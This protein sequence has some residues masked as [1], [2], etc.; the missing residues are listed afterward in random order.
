MDI[1][2]AEDIQI[3]DWTTKDGDI[4]GW[5]HRQFE[6]FQPNKYKLVHVVS[7][8]KDDGKTCLAHY[9]QKI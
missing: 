2:E 9:F 6:V 3:R 5:I 7:Y 4:W 1:R 8:T